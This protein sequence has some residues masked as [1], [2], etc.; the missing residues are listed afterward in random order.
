MTAFLKSFSSRFRSGGST[1]GWAMHYPFFVKVLKPLMSSSHASR[2][3]NNR[4]LGGPLY[5]QHLQTSCLMVSCDWTRQVSVL[6]FGVGVLP[7]R[8]VFDHVAALQL[9]HV[10]CR[11]AVL[12]RCLFELKNT[13]CFDNNILFKCFCGKGYFRLQVKLPA[14]IVWLKRHVVIISI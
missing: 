4:L 2:R 10:V 6:A 13:Q 3:G 9:S 8:C 1:F 12:S 7:R 14:L 5:L 11:A